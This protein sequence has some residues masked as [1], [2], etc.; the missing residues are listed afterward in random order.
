V[1]LLK[2]NRQALDLNIEL[3]TGLTAE[4][5]NMA[6][7]C[8]GWTVHDLLQHQVDQTLAFAAGARGLPT[9]VAMPMDGDP[10]GAYKTVTAQATEAFNA[11]GLLGREIEFPGYG[12]QRGSTV[13]AAHFVDNLVHA[14]DLAKALGLDAT[15]DAEA[16]AAALKISQRYPS[17]PTVRGPDSAFGQ[18]VPAPEDAPITD[19]LVAFLGRSPNW[20][21]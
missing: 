12:V 4:Q 18:P 19:R 2:L 1:D 3:I 20:P 17:D 14:W 21:A 10:L 8:A 9:D 6:T 11:D 16:A 15:L 13:V 7:P 5:L